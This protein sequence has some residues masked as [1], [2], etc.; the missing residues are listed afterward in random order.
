MFNWLKNI[1]RQPTWEEYNRYAEK[2]MPIRPEED[3]N[4]HAQNSEELEFNKNNPVYEKRIEKAKKNLLQNLSEEK[5][6]DILYKL[7]INESMEEQFDNINKKDE[8]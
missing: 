5:K 1:R 7:H 4:A 2:H 3:V 8:K 6:I